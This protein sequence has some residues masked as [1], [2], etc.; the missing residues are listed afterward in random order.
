MFLLDCFI[1]V[2]VMLKNCANN[3]RLYILCRAS[4][5]FVLT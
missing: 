5:R 2:N 1:R 3:K 4:I